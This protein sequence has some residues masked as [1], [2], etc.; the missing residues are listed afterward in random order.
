VVFAFNVFRWQ[1]FGASDPLFT[2]REGAAAID[3]RGFWDSQIVSSVY[4]DL[5][6]SAMAVM[7]TFRTDPFTRCLYALGIEYGRVESLSKPTSYVVMC[8]L[9]ADATP[10]L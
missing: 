7:S 1:T 10:A 9:Q 4:Y 6:L 3:W 8:Q 5:A 2:L